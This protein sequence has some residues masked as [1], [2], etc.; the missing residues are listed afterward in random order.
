MNNP[1]ECDNIICRLDRQDRQDAIEQI[2]KI[3]KD[4][5]EVNAPS[6]LLEI[7]IL[8]EEFVYLEH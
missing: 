3:A 2:Y 8:C 4:A 5:H 6:K 7:A 1:A